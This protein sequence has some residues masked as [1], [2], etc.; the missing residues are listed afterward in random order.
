M[1]NVHYKSILS[2]ADKYIRPVVKIEISCLSLK[3]PYQI[4]LEKPRESVF[5]KLR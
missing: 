3:E 2:P 4:Q 5:A 1:L